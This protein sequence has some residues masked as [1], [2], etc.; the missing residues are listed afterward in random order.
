M[1]L[2]DTVNQ[3]VTRAL[4]SHY[5]RVMARHVPCRQSLLTSSPFPFDLLTIPFSPDLHHFIVKWIILPVKLNKRYCPCLFRS[6]SPF[7]VCTRTLGAQV[8]KQ[9][10]S[11]K[12]CLRSWIMEDRFSETDRDGE[13]TVN[14]GYARRRVAFVVVGAVIGLFVSTGAVAL[15][16]PGHDVASAWRPG[17]TKYADATSIASRLLD[18][19]KAPPSIHRDSTVT[20]S[21][22]SDPSR[23]TVSPSSNRS[24]NVATSLKLSD[25]LICQK[26]LKSN[27]Y[28]R[29][30]AHACFQRQVLPQLKEPCGLV[31]GKTVFHTLSTYFPERLENESRVALRTQ[32]DAFAV[33]Q[34]LAHSVMYV[35]CLEWMPELATDIQ[36]RYESAVQLRLL[37][38]ETLVRSTVLRDSFYDQPP[39]ALAAYVQK[40][41]GNVVTFVDLLKYLLL[42]EHGGI[43]LDVD[44]IP[45]RDFKPLVALGVQIFPHTGRIGNNHMLLFHRRSALM[46]RLLWIIR[47]CDVSN[48]DSCREHTRN[49]SL[50]KLAHWVLNDAVESKLREDVRLRPTD[51]VEDQYSR[52]SI[53]AFDP[54]WGCSGMFQPLADII[55]TRKLEEAFAAGTITAESLLSRHFLHFFTLHSR[56]PKLEKYAAYVDVVRRIT[57][58]VWLAHG[59]HFP[60]AAINLSD[61][62]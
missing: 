39:H 25:G 23:R 31:P 24:Q 22:P 51:D 21:R 33:T 43:W 61:R 47:A 19:P 6:H 37:E 54:L 59:R 30:G 1:W 8:L 57:N 41:I 17:G 28:G 35:W 36:A 44:A 4:L 49:E 20:R 34:N 3:I 7:W 29:H 10:C 56:F 16:W 11:A 48:R 45:M 15:W 46:E 58:D 50:T 32:L 14:F 42:H 52:F 18:R 2:V 5:G 62:P 9:R 60:Q 38:Y 27:A 26:I 13:A 12:V 40:K 53:N 55:A